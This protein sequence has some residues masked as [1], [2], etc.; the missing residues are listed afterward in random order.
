MSTCSLPMSSE[1]VARCFV[2]YP[3]TIQNVVCLFDFG[4]L[5][6]RKWAVGDTAYLPHQQEHLSSQLATCSA[7]IQTNTKNSLPG[8]FI[9]NSSSVTFNI[10]TKD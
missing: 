4:F 10:N 3:P 2:V 7:N 9:F 8:T 5:N 1:G 6:F